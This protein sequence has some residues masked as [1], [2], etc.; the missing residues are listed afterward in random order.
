M[1]DAIENRDHVTQR[2]LSGQLGIALGLTNI[3]LK[4][5]INK[6][7]VKV[8][9]A[10][11]GRGAYYLTAK[12]FGEKARLTAKYLTRSLSFFR[13]ARGDCSDLFGIGRAQGLDRMARVGA[14]DRCEIAIL[15]AL[16]GGIQPVAVFD[17]A[18][19]RQRV[20][21]VPIVL[22][23]AALQAGTA[24]RPGAAAW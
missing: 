3:Y 22:E 6:G 20:A 8:R 12:G 17:E 14:G 9:K 21:G 18:T 13:M 11:A 2:D 5:C 4:R 1:L 7:L 19:N 15:A 24:A 23:L 16:D 10:P